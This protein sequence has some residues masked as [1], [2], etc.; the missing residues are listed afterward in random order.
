MSEV[1]II[2]SNNSSLLPLQLFLILGLG[3]L[4]K[5]SQNAFFFFFFFLLFGSA[6]AAYGSSQARG[7]VRATATS[8]HHSHSNTG[9][10]LCL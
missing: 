3:L 4:H 10:E 9:S 7:Q 1:E 2:H 6:P 5:M 8:L